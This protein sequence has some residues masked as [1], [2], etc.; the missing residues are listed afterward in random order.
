MSKV[1]DLCLSRI[2]TKMMDLKFTIQ[3]L[4]PSGQNKAMKDHISQSCS[5]TLCCLFTKMKTILPICAKDTPESFH[6]R[7]LKFM[8]NNST[9]SREMLRSN[10]QFGF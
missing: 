8:Q 5:L 2:I 9:N 6:N 10:L 3:L 4:L 1:Y 7:N